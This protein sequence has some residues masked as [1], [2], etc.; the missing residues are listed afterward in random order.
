MGSFGKSAFYNPDIDKTKL[1]T[2]YTDKTKLKTAYIDKTKLKTA[3]IDKTKPKT[4]Y[5]DKTK[6]K[7]QQHPVRQVFVR[8]SQLH[9]HHR[10]FMQVFN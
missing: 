2:A 9:L 3:Y 6:P 1:K 4:A 10:L 8:V 7:T 5:T